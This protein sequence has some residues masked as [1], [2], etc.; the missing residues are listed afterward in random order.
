MCPAGSL[1]SCILIYTSVSSDG[2]SA[3]APDT[4]EKHLHWVSSSWLAW[5]SPGHCELLETQVSKWGCAYRWW[6]VCLSIDRYVPVDFFKKDTLINC[7]P[8]YS[9]FHDQSLRAEHEG[10]TEGTKV[11]WMNALNEQKPGWSLEYNGQTCDV[12]EQTCNDKL[13]DNEAKAHDAMKDRMIC[14]ESQKGQLRKLDMSNTQ[15]FLEG[16][17][18]G[19]CSTESSKYINRFGPGEKRRN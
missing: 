11:N 12:T 14:T 17:R 13:W 16:Q 5:H 19:R 4:P 2:L 6:E 9:C 18:G 1:P 10:T 3:W 8:L 7:F 15:P